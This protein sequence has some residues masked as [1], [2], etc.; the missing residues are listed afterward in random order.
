MAAAGKFNKNQ[1]KGEGKEFRE[2]IKNK[3]HQCVDTTIAIA[4]CEK[5]AP[6][7]QPAALCPMDFHAPCQGVRAWVKK[8]RRRA[9]TSDGESLPR[10]GR[11]VY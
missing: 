11:A 4:T 2:K 9:F 1:V 10:S 5:I 7:S 3:A 6:A 8:R